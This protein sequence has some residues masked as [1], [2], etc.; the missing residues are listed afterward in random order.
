MTIS[1]FLAANVHEF[2]AHL[3]TA[4]E[5]SPQEYKK[6]AVNARA[7]VCDKFSELVFGDGVLR[8]LRRCLT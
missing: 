3:K 7:S 6:I 4:I 5:L 8:S 2:A 1:G